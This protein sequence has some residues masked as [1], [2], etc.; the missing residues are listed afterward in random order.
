[1]KSL[2]EKDRMQH[3]PQDVVCKYHVAGILDAAMNL[4]HYLES[5]EKK[6][7]LTVLQVAAYYYYVEYRCQEELLEVL[8]DIVML[9]KVL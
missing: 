3:N 8:L 5:L 7:S 9:T 6:L 2:L 1:M 4:E